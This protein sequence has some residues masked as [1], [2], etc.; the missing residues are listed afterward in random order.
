[1]PLCL[2]SHTYVRPSLVKFL[3]GECSRVPGSTLAQSLKADE[4]L[5]NEKYS[6]RIQFETQGNHLLSVFAGVSEP[7]VDDCLECERRPRVDGGRRLA[8]GGAPS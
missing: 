6:T 5:T 7:A 2:E 4:N 3:L 8:G 1:M